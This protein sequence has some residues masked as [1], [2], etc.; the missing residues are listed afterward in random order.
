MTHK[1]VLLIPASH[2]VAP[3]TALAMHGQRSPPPWDPLSS[4]GPDVMRSENPGTT[5]SDPGRHAPVRE[6]MPLQRGGTQTS[7]LAAPAPGRPT[8][9]A[10]ITPVQD[11]DMDTLLPTPPPSPPPVHTTI[12]HHEETAMRTDSS[13]PLTVPS[14]SELRSV[15][16]RASKFGVPGTPDMSPANMDAR[17][18]PTATAEAFV[19]RA[20]VDWNASGLY[21]AEDA[22][23]ELLCPGWTGAV[24]QKRPDDLPG[25]VDRALYVQLP[26]AFDRSRLRDNMLRILDTASDGV[27]ASRVVFCLE[28]SIP[29]LASLL[30]GMCYVGG[31]LSSIHGQR[32][33]WLQAVPLTSLVLVTVVL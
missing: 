11:Y 12:V 8:R 3:L 4:G 23:V 24:I 30:H 7:S 6:A 2:L 28:R 17:H 29:D 20:F 32:D 10:I 15:L 25:G 19:R 5:I 9:L 16:D 18:L 13:V 31:H 1:L 21:Q 14:A 26:L 22:G 27:S 33:E